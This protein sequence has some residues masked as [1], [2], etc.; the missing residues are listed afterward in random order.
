M[1]S[2]IKKNVYLV[3]IISREYNF[4]D[5]CRMKELGKQVVFGREQLD[6]ILN[7]YPYSEYECI[8]NNGE[9]NYSKFM[10]EVTKNEN[11]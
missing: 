6:S 1:N 10:A 9:E 7:I 5:L 4:G 2:S 11:I 8:E 3:K